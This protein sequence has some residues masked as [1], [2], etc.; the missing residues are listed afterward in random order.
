MDRRT[1]LGL[2]RWGQRGSRSGWARSREEG[3]GGLFGRLPVQA[4]GGFEDPSPDGVVLWTRLAPDP[5]NG[6]GAPNQNF[7]V[8]WEVSADEGFTRIVQSGTETA[9]PEYGHSV[10]VEV[11]GLEPARYYW[12]RF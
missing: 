5:L 4:R 1:F 8:R 7:A 2:G 6:G 9:T 12:Y 10:H 3:L 11:E